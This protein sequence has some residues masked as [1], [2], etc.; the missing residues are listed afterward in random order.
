MPLVADAVHI[1]VTFLLLDRNRDIEIDI[2]VEYCYDTCQLLAP[3]YRIQPLYMTTSIHLSQHCSSIPC[4]S[5][6]NVLYNHQIV[7]KHARRRG[8]QTRDVAEGSGTVPI[9]E[10]SE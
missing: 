9:E 8:E 5:C 4:S 6:R 3:D 7:A 2:A 10:R 1:T